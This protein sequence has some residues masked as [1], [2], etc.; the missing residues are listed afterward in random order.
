MER[1][2]TF[3]PQLTFESDMDMEAKKM[4]SSSKVKSNFG[5]ANLPDKCCGFNVT[6]NQCDFSR[7]TRFKSL[8][9]TM[10][11]RLRDVDAAL[12]SMSV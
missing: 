12:T 9:A 3:L 11:A 1:I 6:T 5:T 2:G 8:N 7:G 10:M 4:H